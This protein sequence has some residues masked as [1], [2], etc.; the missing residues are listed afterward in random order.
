VGRSLVPDLS[1]LQPLFS[2]QWNGVPVASVAVL[3]VGGAMYLAMSA[4]SA[5]GFRGGGGAAPSRGPGWAA[6]SR[7]RGGIRHP[8]GRVGVGYRSAVGAVHLSERELAHHGALFGGPGSGKTTFLELLVE[9]SAG[10]QPIVIVDPKGS[11]ALAAAVRAQGGMVWRLDGSLSAD[12]LDPRPWQVPDLLLEAEDYSPEAR[13]FRDAAHQRALWAAWALALRGERMD[14]Q[15]LRQLLERQALTDA[16][17][18][19]RHR[20]RRVS[21]WLDRLQRRDATEDAGTRDLE[22]ALGTLLDGVAMRGSLSTG[23][24]ALRLEDVLQT[25]GVVLFSLDVADYPHAT[26]KVAAWVLLAMGR[27]ARQL[28][29]MHLQRVGRSA[30]GDV[31]KMEHA[32]APGA[33]RALLLVDEVGA[34]G[35]QARHLRG[36]VGRARESGLA[37]VLAT[38][39]P[40]DVEAVDRA[41]LNQVLQDTAWQLAF[42]QGSPADARHME[43]LFGQAWADDYTRWSDGRSSSRQVERPRVPID[44]WMNGLQPG[45]AWLRVAPVD[46]G[47]RQHRVRVALPTRKVLSESASESVSEIKPPHSGPHFP[48]PVAGPPSGPSRGGLPADGGS[49]AS[50]PSPPPDCPQELLERMGADILG[51]VDKRWASTRRELG[52]CLVWRDGEPTLLEGTYGRIY[53]PALKRSDAAHLVVWRRCYP[54]KPIPKGMTVDHLCHVTLCQRPDHLQGPVTRAENTRRRHARTRRPAESPKTPRALQRF[55]VALFAGVD[56][57]RVQ[58]RQLELDEL[59]ELLTRF[60]ILADKRRGRCWSPTLYADGATTRSNAGVVSVSALV[61]DLDRVPPDPKRLAGVCWIAHTT[62]SHRPDTPKWRLIVPLGTPIAAPNWPVTW[63]RAR[64]ALCPEAD[65]ACKDA[66]RE[67]YLPSHPT[68]VA[69]SAEHHDGRLLDPLT[70]PELP[71]DAPRPELRRSPTAQV[72]RRATGADRRRGEA[73]LATVIDGLEATP[74]GRRNAALNAAAWTLGRWVAAGALDQADVEDALYG[75]AEINDL[76]DDDG[77]RQCWATIRSGLSA[78]LLEPIDLHAAR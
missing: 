3:V 19:F 25:C 56:R 18:P 78:G 28:P 7:A 8:R 6:R 32:A 71:P 49:R 26:R 44:E 40:S 69:P 62:W 33:P 35:D 10:R 9:A 59:V 70:L 30:V 63:R 66:S 64:A 27:L 23:P 20:D 22:R 2:A 74:P 52:P 24:D 34:L 46:R 43:A 51:K 42:R 21:D 77:T 68:G 1:T 58:P 61:F 38:Q 12:L 65:P 29:E 75:A 4:H 55:A 13:V 76:V 31:V 11:P 73:Y 54:D 14:L 67:Y 53:D 60:E 45:D 17:A 37:V 5:G 47:W 50:L 39:G 41:L 57:P 48:K 16:L 15:R 72:L 36:L